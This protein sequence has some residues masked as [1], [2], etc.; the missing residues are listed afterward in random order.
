MVASAA[1]A[2]QQQQSAALLKRDNKHRHAPTVTSMV[3]RKSFVLV[4]LILAVGAMLALHAPPVYSSVADSRST[5]AETNP[6]RQI[7]ILGERNSGTRW[8]F[9]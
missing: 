2:Q 6:I 3:Q 5:Q 4:T 8:T 1:A 7:S 9:E